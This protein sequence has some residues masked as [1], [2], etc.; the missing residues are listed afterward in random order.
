MT[1]QGPRSRPLQLHENTQVTVSVS[2]ATAHHAQSQPA[3]THCGDW[4]APTSSPVLL[5]GGAGSR[6]EPG[7]PGEGRHQALCPEDSDQVWWH[8]ES[9][10]PRQNVSPSCLVKS[11]RY[12]QEAGTVSMIYPEPIR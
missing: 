9:T 4:G 1:P 7:E 5:A 3:P 10:D 8:L 11:C 2:A 6:A 12:R